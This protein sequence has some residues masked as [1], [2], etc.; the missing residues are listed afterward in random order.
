VLDRF[1]SHMQAAQVRVTAVP[2]APGLRQGARCEGLRS[3]SGADQVFA[4]KETG[5]DLDQ[6]V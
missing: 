1:L 6:H 2:A 4:L 3:R 5:R